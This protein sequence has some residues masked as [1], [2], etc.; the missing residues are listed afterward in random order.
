MTPK[1]K[2]RR[3]KHQ[4]HFTRRMKFYAQAALIRMIAVSAKRNETNRRTRT[5][6]LWQCHNFHF[7]HLSSKWK[8]LQ[9]KHKATYICMVLFVQERKVRK[10]MQSRVHKQIEKT[11]EILRN[12]PKWHCIFDCIVYTNQ[13]RKNVKTTAVIAN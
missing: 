10:A 4:I 5:K 6:T 3:Y 11:R 7:S 2:T 8:V 9:K 12:Q 13:R 1:R